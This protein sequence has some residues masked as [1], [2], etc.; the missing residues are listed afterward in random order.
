MRITSTPLHRKDNITAQLHIFT[1]A[2][3]HPIQIDLLIL[4]ANSTIDLLKIEKLMSLASLHNP[5]KTLPATKE[6][7][8]E[9]CTSCIS[10]FEDAHHTHS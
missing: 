8:T 2:H 5:S 6:Q 7:C 9:I 1:S 3:P 4:N 10:V